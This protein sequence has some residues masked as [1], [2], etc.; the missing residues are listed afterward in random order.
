MYQVEREK[1]EAELVNRHVGL[2]S[3]IWTTAATQ[4]YITMTAHFTSD[5]WEFCSQVLLTRTP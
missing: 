4:E 5:G 2:T 3:N 1:L